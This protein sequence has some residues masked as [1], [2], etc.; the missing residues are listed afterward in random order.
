MYVSSIALK[1]AQ[2]GV[3]FEDSNTDSH[4]VMVE[5]IEPTA[6]IVIN[7]DCRRRG[8]G[9][10]HNIWGRMHISKSDVDK[11]WMSTRGDGAHT[12]KAAVL[13]RGSSI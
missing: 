3:Q 9:F 13:F 6:I 11:V 8:N 4:I 12:C 1:N 5:R 7:P 2:G 10:Q